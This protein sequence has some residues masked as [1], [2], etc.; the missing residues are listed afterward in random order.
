MQTGEPAAQP[1]PPAGTRD[2][3]ATAGPAQG[4]GQAFDWV[5]QACR[6][7][8]FPSKLFK[9]TCTSVP[10]PAWSGPGLALSVFEWV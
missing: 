6:Q 3:E 7:A 4:P 9:P 2:S 8:P 10:R 5:S 1:G